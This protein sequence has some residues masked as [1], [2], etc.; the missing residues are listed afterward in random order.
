MKAILLLSGGIDSATLLYI[1]LRRKYEITALTFDYESEG[2]REINAARE[3]AKRAGVRHEVY[4]IEFYKRLRNSPSSSHTKIF[5]SDKGISNAYVPARNI[6]FFGLAAAL[7]ESDDASIIMSGHNKGDQERFPDADSKFVRAI[8]RVIQLGLKNKDIRLK[9][10]MPLRRFNKI[11]VLK[12]AIRLKVPLELTWSCY[13]NGEEPCNLCYGCI[14][15]KNAFNSL[16]VID[17]WR[18]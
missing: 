6:V 12:R 5:D 11:Q 18:R 17:P 1:M 16:G 3:I 7:A 13:N 9:V 2:S 8:N 10:A 15:R 14:S 4:E